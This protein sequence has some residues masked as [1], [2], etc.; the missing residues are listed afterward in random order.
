MSRL[1]LVACLL[2][3]CSAQTRRTQVI[4]EI[5]AEPGVVDDAESLRVTIMGGARGDVLT[6]QADQILGNAAE[7]I[8]WPVTAALVPAG[9]D[10]ERVFL[11]EAEATD[12]F[13]ST[14]G[15]VRARS[16]YVAGQT[17]VLRLT[18][19]ECCRMVA[20]S[21]SPSETCRSCA[22]ATAEVPV[23]SLPDYRS[24]AS[25]DPD[26][27]VDS[28]D[29]AVETDAGSD[30]GRDTGRDA[31]TPTP[32]TGTGPFPP[33]D[34]GTEGDP[35]DVDP[36]SPGAGSCSAGRCVGTSR[37]SGGCVCDGAMPLGS[38]Y[39]PTPP[40]MACP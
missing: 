31:S 23:E 32:D 38:C 28:T 36:C 4:V 35:C 37:C 14:L 12:S 30:A 19:E 22:C 6:L 17:L 18:L 24:D 11:V 21:C 27:G 3:G 5:F 34:G 7:A 2:L 15:I 20:S 29:T 26:G 9:E 1:A 10:P 16:S 8:S 39:D 13:G 25:T 40:V 33:C